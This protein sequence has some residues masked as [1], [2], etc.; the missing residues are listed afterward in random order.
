MDH[1]M[2]EVSMIGLTLLA[3]RLEMTESDVFLDVGAG[4]GNVLAQLAF[5]SRANALVGIEMRESV[6]SRCNEIFS[7]FSKRHQEL[8]KLTV[9]AGD[10][11]DD[12]VVG[13]DSIKQCTIL[14]SFNK[15]F[16]LTANVRLEYMCCCLPAL[17]LVV[18]SGKFCPRHD[19]RRTCMNEFCMLWKL[20]EEVD[21]QVTYSSKPVKFSIYD[22]R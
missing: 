11:R 14:Y 15:V 7:A 2:G 12:A 6:V 22:R 20:R 9:I 4:I 18:V 3:S 1:N 21:V 10:I 8:K 5:Q 13:G 19:R 16:H 17:R